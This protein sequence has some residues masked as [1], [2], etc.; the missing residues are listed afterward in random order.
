LWTSPESAALVAALEIMKARGAVAAD[1]RVV[2]VLTG[3]GF[4]YDP[5]ALPAPV[6]LTG[7]EDDIVAAV[8]RAV[9][10]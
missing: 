4:K 6:D 5:P 1:A 8:R 10:V 7:S 2:L 3:A 9:G